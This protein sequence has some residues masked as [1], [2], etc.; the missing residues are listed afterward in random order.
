VVVPKKDAN[1]LKMDFALPAILY[2]PIAS[3]QRVGEVIVRNGGEVLTTF[4]A[5][6]PINAGQQQSLIGGTSAAAMPEAAA[7]PGATIRVAPAAIPAAVPLNTAVTPAA[8]AAANFPAAVV[9][10]T[11]QIVP[12]RTN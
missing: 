10:A 8:A 7:E 4:D 2:G 5:I 11:N 12:A 3:D 6:C 1:D 9:P